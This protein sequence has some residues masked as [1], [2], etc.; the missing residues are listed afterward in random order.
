MC[1]DNRRNGVQGSIFYSHVECPL[2]L[3]LLKNL[4][5]AENREFK[6]EVQDLYFKLGK[7]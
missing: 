6:R 5:K 2:R 4:D 7:H 1:Q 3:L